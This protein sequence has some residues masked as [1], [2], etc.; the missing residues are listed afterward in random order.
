MIKFLYYFRKV[1][2]GK[3]L[4]YNIQQNDNIFTPKKPQ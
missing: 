3:I 1:F 2:R 4:L